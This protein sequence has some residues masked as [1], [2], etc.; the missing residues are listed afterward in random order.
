MVPA[1]P[2]SSAALYFVVQFPLQGVVVI[3]VVADAIKEQS[4]QAKQNE[5]CSEQDD[6]IKSAA[7]LWMSPTRDEKQSIMP[8]PAETTA[9]H[10]VCTLQVHVP[11]MSITSTTTISHSSSNSIPKA[12]SLPL[13]DK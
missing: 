1:P 4:S 3:V 2:S 5:V 7:H 9:I 8:N 10:Q 13:L 6:A 11:T 12:V